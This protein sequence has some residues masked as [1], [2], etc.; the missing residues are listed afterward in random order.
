MKIGV[1]CPSYF[2]IY[3][4]SVLDMLSHKYIFGKNKGLIR[5][6]EK[7]SMYNLFRLLHNSELVYTD[8]VRV[9]VPMHSIS[10][11][12]LPFPFYF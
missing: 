8:S 12:N 1:S 3:I 7:F 9:D 4:E 2:L 6:K 11:S 5:K 10:K